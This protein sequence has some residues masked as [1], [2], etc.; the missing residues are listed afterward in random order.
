[1]KMKLGHCAYRTSNMD[2]SLDFYCN[3]LG[4]KKHFTLKDP[5]GDV[6]LIYLKIAEGGEFLELFSWEKPVDNERSAF[7]HV[8]LL[9]EDAKKAADALQEKGIDVYYGPTW[10]GNKAPVP[11]VNKRGKCGCYCFYIEDPD[12]N[13]VEFQQYTEMSLQT[14]TP[15]QLK[16]VEP[17]VN[18]NTYIKD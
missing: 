2:R 8:C 3:K 10:L 16:E 6:W 17:L 1:M 18:R 4:L 5:D 11:F 13:Q 12:G 9:V 15:Q 7:Q 14:M